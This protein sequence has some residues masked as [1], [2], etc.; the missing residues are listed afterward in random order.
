M[1]KAP[2]KG[3]TTGISVETLQ[4]K[5]KRTPLM[6]EAGVVSKSVPSLICDSTELEWNQWNLT[7]F[8][9]SIV[10]TRSQS[11]ITCLFMITNFT[12]T[13]EFSGQIEILMVVFYFIQ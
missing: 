1:S 5:R 13:E 10:S 12:L 11:N 3:G 4:C 2:D 8:K 7:Q 9:T 6:E